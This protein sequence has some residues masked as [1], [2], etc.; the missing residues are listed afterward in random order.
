LKEQA[1]GRH[2]KKKKRKVE[3]EEEKEEKPTKKKTK[4][5]TNEGDEN[6]VVDF[7][8]LR[9]ADG[10]MPMFLPQELLDAIPAQREET[11]QWDMQS[12]KGLVVRN[13]HEYKGIVK[14]PLEQKPKDLT[15]GSLSVSVLEKKN[16]FLAPMI[17]QKAKGV[18]ENW[19][20]GRPTMAAQAKQSKGARNKGGRMERRVWGAAKA[21]S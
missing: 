3:K 1:S 15:V 4:V 9:D 17:V 11:P 6:K 18:R 13:I 10:K 8:G 20:R 2:E 7:E 12:Q 21:F 16:K 5:T 14:R 19:L